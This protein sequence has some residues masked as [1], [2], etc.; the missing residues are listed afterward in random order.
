MNIKPVEINRQVAN[1]IEQFNS[2]VIK[3]KPNK[4]C[5]FVI[6]RQFQNNLVTSYKSIR[7]RN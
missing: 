5:L 2:I 1:D 6:Q 7:L 4:N 3:I